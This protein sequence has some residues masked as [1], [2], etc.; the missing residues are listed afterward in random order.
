MALTCLEG[1]G[2]RPGVVLLGRPPALEERAV[3]YEWKD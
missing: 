2:S 3:R 1:L